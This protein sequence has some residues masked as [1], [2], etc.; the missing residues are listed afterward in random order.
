MSI[1]DATAR[2]KVLNFTSN[3]AALVFFIIAGLPLWKVGLTMALGNF[4]GARLGAKMVITKGSKWI[5]PMV[6]V[7][8][9][10]IAVKLLWEQHPQ[11]WQSVF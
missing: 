7:M 3:L 8:S 2:T 10:L 1:V 9:M 6:I 11:W 5:R 4:L